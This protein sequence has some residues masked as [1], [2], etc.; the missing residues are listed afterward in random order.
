M[1]F[2]GI[3]SIIDGRQQDEVNLVDGSD[4]YRRL[5]EWLVSP[6]P[7]TVVAET[8]RSALRAELNPHVHAGW[9]L[10]LLGS[11]ELHLV[12]PGVAHEATGLCPLS[13]EAGAGGMTLL[14]E[15]RFLF[16]NRPA[17]PR[18][19]FLP[20]LF[21][22]LARIPAEEERLRGQLLRA[23]FEAVRTLARSFESV[24]DAP[25]DRY[26]LALDYLKRNYYKRELGVEDLAAFI[27]VTPQYLNRL[28]RRN[29][30]SGIRR[31]LIAIRL[32]KARE[33]LESGNYLVSDAA[34]LTG[35][36]CPFYFCNSFKRHYG[37]PPVSVRG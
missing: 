18:N 6:P 33:L 37:V 31:Q 28:F 27:G 4:F 32:E 16:L 36:S 30:G 3:R 23:A 25:E 7:L 24:P 19:N 2:A 5:E 22:L 13:L 9:E 11:G 26:T 15:G 12:P 29:G 20:E 8:E 34:R 21:A 1:R 14:F 10:K 35:W 17:G